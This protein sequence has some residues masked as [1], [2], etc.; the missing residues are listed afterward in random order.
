MPANSQ[1]TV[2]PSRATA[3]DILVRVER[4]AA[5]ANE[6]L[7]SRAV[8][9]LT[10]QDRGLCMEI[11]MGV[12]RWR[13]RLDMAIAQYSFTPF[14]RLDFEVL[15]ALRIGAYQLMFLASI[16]NRAAVN[17]SVMLVKRAK[18]K[19]AAALVNVILRKI[20]ANKANHPV[21]TKA[22]S[23]EITGVSLARQFA[24]PDWLVER[25]ISNYGPEVAAEI[26]AFDQQ[27]PVTAV[28]LRADDLQTED[29][30]LAPGKLLRSARLVE[31]GDITHTPACRDSQV[32]IQDEGSQLV[33]ALV[34]HGKRIL[35]CC[36]APG[37]KTWAIA[38]R[39]PDAC[40]I[41]A[42]LHAHRTR[43]MQQLVKASN[44]E[45]ITAD[46]THL[47]ISG[48]FDRILA[49]V[50]CSGTG[51][52]ARNPEIK[53]RLKFSDLTDLQQRQTAIL[54]ASL[55]R[56]APSG[57]LI[58]STCSLESEENEQ[59]VEEV[60]KN[61][62]ASFRLISCLDELSRLNTEGE[63]TWPDPVSLTHG[64]YLRTVPG[65]HPCDGFFAA[66]IE[67]V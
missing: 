1:Q 17:E 2:T 9:K 15:T 36:A 52:L 10:P 31:T 41:A 61:K 25:W 35:D 11:V 56:L 45:F 26:C 59:I 49:D 13:S 28:R 6:L 22:G 64:P 4:D 7:H 51:T 57:R 37:G 40:I 48:E 24:H 63:L 14:P 60:L 8:D 50:P 58:Y 19:S 47:T 21:E 66:I 38:D 20:A 46:A 32:V 67:K 16:P 12:L 27:I 43:L 23:R 44:I 39:N 62:G 18:K 42:D 34:G 55:D 53:W 5:Y 54:T 3:F 30:A 29:V 65:L 33:A